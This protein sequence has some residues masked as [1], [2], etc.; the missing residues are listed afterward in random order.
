VIA[1]NII[2]PFDGNHAD[3]PAGFTRDTRFDS[4][5]PVHA[6]AGIGGTGG[7]DTHTHT[8]SAHYHSL[9]HHTHSVSFGNWTGSPSD[10]V[11]ASSEANSISTHAHNTAN[12]STTSSANSS[13]DAPTTAA[14]SSLPP[15]YSV[16]Y[17]KASGYQ[18]IPANG[19][20]FSQTTIPG[21]TL[22]DGGSGTPDLEGKFLRGAA[23]GA[24]A[25][26][27]GGTTN[28]SHSANH[29]HTSGA[30][31]THN[32]TS[33]SRTGS[34]IRRSYRDPRNATSHM[35][36]THTY[37]TGS[38][39]APIS[40]ASVTVGADQVI[41]PPY[42]T[43]KPFKNI[44]GSGKIIHPGAIAITTETTIPGGWV[45]CNGDSGT[46][47]LAGKYI[48]A[49]DTAG[50]TGGATTHTHPA[51]S[52]THSSTGHTHAGTTN[53]NSP[54][55]GSTPDGGSS[56]AS[57]APNGHTHSLSAASASATYASSNLTTNAGS[58][59]PAYIEV[60]YIMATGGAIATGQPLMAL[61]ENTWT[62]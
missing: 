15:Y 43:L 11:S 37:T 35:D 33:G 10:L 25:G 22:C 6:D 38:G 50:S 21:L 12:N 5:I 34:E 45:L 40:S 4:R 9:N 1:P 13:S 19:I 59:I 32:G 20:L 42:T 57:A 24:N 56:G 48:R 7:A 27:T 60:K 28:H 31:H 47:N 62:Y 58:S 36:H 30:S 46:P 53:G 26:S 3:I 41:N 8:S 29:S 51:V 2:I 17:I 18:M 44:S 23:T 49:S 16:I 39:T 52:H 54:T 14:G 61:L 55:T